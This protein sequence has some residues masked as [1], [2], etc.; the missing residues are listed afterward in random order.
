MTSKP[1]FKL[2]VK[3]EHLTSRNVAFLSAVKLAVFAK[4]CHDGNE[5]FLGSY[6]MTTLALHT[7]DAIYSANSFPLSGL[8]IFGLKEFCCPL[9]NLNNFVSE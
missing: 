2:V 7:C 3:Y 9:N 6:S 8:Q 5:H 4:N 1:V